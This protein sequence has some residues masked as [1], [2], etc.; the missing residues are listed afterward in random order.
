MECQWDD[1]LIIL[2]A[3]THAYSVVV[4]TKDQKDATHGR[5]LV[6]IASFHF[7]DCLQG[8]IRGHNPAE[9]TRL[10]FYTVSP[11]LLQWRCLTSSPFTHISLDGLRIVRT[12]KKHKTWCSRIHLHEV[13][14][15]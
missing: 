3:C 12:T 5:Q 11:S 13:R 9:M 7:A 15:S 10:R 2:S 14:D 4:H 1:L 6:V 8:K